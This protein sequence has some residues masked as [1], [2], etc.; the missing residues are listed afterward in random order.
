MA[1]EEEKQLAGEAGA[2]LVEAGMRVGLGTGTTVAYLLA[3]LA[4][5]SV[6]AVYVATSP[7]TE[8]AARALGLVLEPF[9]H[10]G[11]LDLAIDGADQISADGWLIK[12]GGG[13]HTRE[14]I[15]AASAT[16]FVVIAD[17]S[18]LVDT[19]HA[20]VPLELLA[21]GIDATLRHLSPTTLRDITLSP[22]G[23]LIADYHGEV[24]DPEQLARWLAD[25]PG[26]LGHGLFNPQLVS[27]VLVGVGGTV[28]RSP[29]R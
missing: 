29:R 5:R 13:A 28:Q 4:E 2:Q 23:G 22:D 9:E 6:D 8:Q 1:L 12:G 18:K 15:V 24:G 27:D 14:K 10:L 26:V 20:P 19:L 3:A 16:R 25:T 17:S 7:Q 11:Q 21:F